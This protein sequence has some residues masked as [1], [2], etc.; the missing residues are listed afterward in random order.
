M[1]LIKCLLVMEEEKK[2]LKVDD[3]YFKICINLD[4]GLFRE[5]IIYL[6][7]DS[8]DIIKSYIVVIDNKIFKYD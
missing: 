2:L 3:K 1:E 6:E 5:K 4:V 8:M 7:E